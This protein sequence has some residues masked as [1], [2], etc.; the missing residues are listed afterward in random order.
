MAF[1]WP[2]P[3]VLPSPVQLD[4]ARVSLP[5]QIFVCVACLLQCDELSFS[6]IPYCLGWHI[7]SLQHSFTGWHSLPQPKGQPD[8]T[9][10]PDASWHSPTLECCWHC[11]AVVARRAHPWL[12]GT[13]GL[14]AGVAISRRECRTDLMFSLLFGSGREAKC[15]GCDSLRCPVL[16]TQ[17]L[18]M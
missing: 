14:T 1:T 10:C 7:L 13:A 4:G 3:S 18:R 17:R 5:D 8:A 2:A 6:C 15:Q 16:S 12:R 11:V 9:L